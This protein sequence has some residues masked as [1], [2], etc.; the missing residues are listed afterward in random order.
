MN[1]SYHKSAPF[2]GS[3]RERLIPDPFLSPRSADYAV[4]GPGYEAG[5]EARNEARNH[6]RNKARNEARNHARNET[7]PY[8]TCSSVDIALPSAKS[9]FFPLHTTNRTDEAGLTN[10]LPYLEVPVSERLG[11]E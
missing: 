5:Y 9:T 2:C 11:N 1:I 7:S 8:L 10:S 3:I 6:A 4:K